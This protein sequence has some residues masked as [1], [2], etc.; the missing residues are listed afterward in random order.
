MSV[1][2][3]KCG[4]PAI[5]ADHHH[6][7]A[8]PRIPIR[9]AWLQPGLAD[10]VFAWFDFGQGLVAACHA[11]WYDPLK[12]RR[13]VLVGSEAMALYQGQPKEHLLVLDRGYKPIE[14]VD[15]FGNRGLS[16]FDE[17]VQPV[18]LSAE[19]PLMAELRAFLDSVEDGHPSAGETEGILR[20]TALL[21]AVEESLREAGRPVEVAY[22]KLCASPW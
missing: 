18:S 6:E 4:A 22:P 13:L 14:G 11:G 7:T 20:T 17:G 2:E 15:A 3:S 5:I 8:A 10:V 12:V 9:F 21:E 16:L 1:G 19:E